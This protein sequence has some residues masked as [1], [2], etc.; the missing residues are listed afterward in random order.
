MQLTIALPGLL[1]PDL[2]DIDYLYSQVK[3]KHLD[4]L[5][6]HSKIS[7]LDFGYSDLIYN[8]H[9][10]NTQV[11]SPEQSKQS[12]SSLAKQMAEK[13]NVTSEFADFLLAEP[14]HLRADRD[15]LLISEAELLQ[16]DA[17]EAKKI[18]QAINQH[19]AGEIKL[20]YLTAELWLIG[21]NLIRG[22]NQFY[23][24]LDIIGENIDDYLPKG[25]NSILY[26]KLLN[27]IQMLL[28]S[29]KV[30]KLRQEEG[31]LVVNSLWLWD[32]EINPQTTTKYKK[33]IANNLA[34]HT[35]H[36]KI[37]PSDFA[38][39]GG[40]LDI[41]SFEENIQNNNILIIDSLYYPC[42][43]RDSYAWTSKL[44]LI[45]QQLALVLHDWLN[46]KKIT[47]LCILIP[48]VNKTL[49]LEMRKNNKYK[50][51]QPKNNLIA[52]S[53][54]LTCCVKV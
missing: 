14:T 50:F 41:G 49:Q 37:A 48:M 17:A 23:P 40:A 47:K 53:R 44:E 43:Y 51:W 27:E 29:L 19:F 34:D 54:G 5:I 4:F 21:L 12:T 52:L 9:G 36:V 38:L 42:R 3:L 13:L 25:Q 20:Y 7:T 18:I 45:E 32:K 2:G 15:R 33:F 31:S 8:C 6:K 16:L 10:A 11:Q 1:W 26:S 35:N 28:F 46:T 24:I 39:A 30:N 22:D